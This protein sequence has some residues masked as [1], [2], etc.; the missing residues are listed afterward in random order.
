MP[1]SSSVRWVTKRRML[2]RM[3]LKAAP[4]WRTSIAPSGLMGPVSR[5]LPKSSAAEARRR[6]ARTWFFMNSA[7]TVKSSRE[8]PMIQ[9]TKR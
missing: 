6:S 9:M 2:A 4:A 5:P 7:A 8:D 3:P 1:A